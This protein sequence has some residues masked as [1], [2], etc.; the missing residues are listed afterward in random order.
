MDGCV[1]NGGCGAMA[2]SRRRQY[3]NGWSA[4]RKA[5]R[6]CVLVH[7]G[8]R[9]HVDQHTPLLQASEEC[10]HRSVVAG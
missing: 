1:Q 5:L 8:M 9:G 3:R 7:Q 2:P 4:V 6:K 10:D